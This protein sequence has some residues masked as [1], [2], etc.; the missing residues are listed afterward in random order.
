[1]EK[2]ILRCGKQ[3][4]LQMSL[5]SSDISLLLDQNDEKLGKCKLNGTNTSKNPHDL[6]SQYPP[7]NFH[8]RWYAGY[9]SLTYIFVQK[10]FMEQREAY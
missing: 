2:F 5:L 10:V 8:T 9:A 6:V 1:M 3:R 7:F 4:K